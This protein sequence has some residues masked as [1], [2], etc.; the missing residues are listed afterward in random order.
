[1]WFDREVKI[2]RSNKV[3]CA[4]DPSYFGSKELLSSPVADVLNDRVRK[5]PV[6]GAISKWQGTAVGYD[7]TD[8]G[9]MN[10]VRQTDVNPGYSGKSFIQPLEFSIY[11]DTT[12]N[13]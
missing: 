7:S 9:F 13:V 1:M 5:G 12:T 11:P 4:C 3:S 6:K 2:R 8:P 10:C